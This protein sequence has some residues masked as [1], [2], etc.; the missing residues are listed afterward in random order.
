MDE[1]WLWFEGTEAH[2][3]RFCIKSG[4]GPLPWPHI[5]RLHTASTRSSPTDS[6]AL[7]TMPCVTRSTVASDTAALDIGRFSMPVR[8]RRAG[9]RAASTPR[10]RTPSPDGGGRI[11]ESETHRAHMMETMALELSRMDVCALNAVLQYCVLVNR[12]MRNT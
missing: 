11:A 4:R 1:T 12:A 7:L 2:L 8:K 10:M 9:S 6:P 5:C 3:G